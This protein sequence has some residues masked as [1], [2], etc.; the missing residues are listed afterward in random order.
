MNIVR[1]LGNKKVLSTIF[2]TTLC[3]VGIQRALTPQSLDISCDPRWT[4]E[5]QKSLKKYLETISIR[6]IGATRLRNDLQTTYPFIK[7]IT[8]A[9]ESALRAKVT[10]IG[11]RPRVLVQSSHVGNKDYVLCETGYTLEKYHFAPAALQGVPTFIVEGTDFEA[12]RIVPECIDTALRL[13]NK[14]YETYTIVWQT[15][16]TILLHDKEKKITILADINSIHDHDRFTYVE[17]IYSH[18]ENYKQGMKADI[19]LKDSIVCSPITHYTK[20]HEEPNA[21]Q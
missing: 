21:L 1:L 15:K 19:R 5:H 17:R 18:E 20:K 6:T 16:T 8:I 11:W 9:Y 10:L 4:A 12:K 2:G 3:V 7:D 14:H 13:T